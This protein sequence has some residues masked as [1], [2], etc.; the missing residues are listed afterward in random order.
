MGKKSGPKA[1]AAPDPVATAQAQTQ[2]NKESAVAQANLNRIDQYTPQGNLTYER[3]GTNADGTPKYKQTQTLS[4]DEQAK[5]DQ[6]NQVA[7]ALNGLAINNVDRVTDTQGK[8]FSYDGMTPMRTSAG[9][10]LPGLIFGIGAKDLSADGKRIADSV[11]GQATSRLDPQFQQ[12]ESDMRARLAAQGISENSDAYRREVDNFSRGK[13]DAYADA[14][15]RSIQAGADEQSR[16]FGLEAQQGAFGNQ[17]RAQGFN[18]DTANATLTN[19]GRQQQ[20]AEATYL[21]NLPLNEIAAL[22]G[23]G[24]PVENPSFQPVSQVGVA[25]PDY[26]GGVANNY[27]QAMNRY[28]QQQ[29]NRSAG[30]GSIF[31]ALGS[32]GGAVAMSDLRVKRNIQRIGQLANGL[33]TYTYNYVGSRARQFGVMAQ[34]ALTV[35]PSAVGR[36]PN[37]LMYVNYAEVY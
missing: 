34:E 14:N 1:P 28:N 18:E 31:G 15:Y 33:A 8:A 12:S 36:L 3:T 26:Q 4:P 11:Y 32:I 19:S 2:M 27:N 23:T 5:Y 16:L 22:L 35:V 10:N 9:E 13:N 20:I 25:A 21:R 24:S 30:L 17:A 29:A 7:M 37:G 6:N